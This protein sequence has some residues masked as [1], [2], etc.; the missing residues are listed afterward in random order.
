MNSIFGENYFLEK[1]DY[2]DVCRRYVVI[3][4]THMLKY[5]YQKQRQGTSWIESIIN[6][7]NKAHGLL[8]K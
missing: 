7:R 4:F 3:C 6:S 8:K 1:A 2:S 5:Q